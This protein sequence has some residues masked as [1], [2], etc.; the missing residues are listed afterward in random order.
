MG[1]IRV[2]LYT[3]FYGQRIEFGLGWDQAA[4]RGCLHVHCLLSVTPFSQDTQACFLL[5]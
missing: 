3:P 4:G 5:I 1:G 2:L